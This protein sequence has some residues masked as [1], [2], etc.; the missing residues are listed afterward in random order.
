ME[1]SEILTKSGLNEKEA[2]IYLAALELGTS[3]V[4]AIADKA[5]IKRPTTYVIL[6][7]LENKGLV[8]LVPRSRKVLYS[9][10]SPEKIVQNL[11]KQQELMKRFLPNMLAVYNTKKEKPQVLLYEGREA[12]K[13]LYD[14]ILDAKEVEFF[15]TIRDFVSIYPDYIDKLVAKTL[16]K[17][18][19]VRE[20]LTQHKE[21]LAFAK[22]A[23]G[24]DY[25]Q[26]K[27]T[28]PGEEFLTD[29][30]LFDGNVV[31]FSF[32]PH[33]F[34]I[35]IQSK[36]IHQSLRTLFEIAWTHSEPYEKIVKE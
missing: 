9:A 22:R 34:A 18:T 31:F 4:H 2:S 19:K 28:K 8:S 26:Q 13:G 1:I 35:V 21:D 36:A 5:G 33:I 24:S 14:R 29:N 11:N 25:Y 10:E 12:I 17:K 30:V 16:E 32:E 3:S 6:K 27:F 20:I 7:Q 23:R 15:A